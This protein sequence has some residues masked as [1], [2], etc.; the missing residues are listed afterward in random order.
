MRFLVFKRILLR[1]KTS[2]KARG[3]R[4]SHHYDVRTHG[5]FTTGRIEWDDLDDLDDL[6]DNDNDSAFLRDW[7]EGG[8]E[9]GD[10]AEE[11]LE[12]GG[13][14]W[15]THIQKSRVRRRVVGI[16]P[17]H[18]DIILGKIQTRYGNLPR[19]LD[20]GSA[21]NFSQASFNSA[22]I[23][24]RISDCRGNVGEDHHHRIGSRVP[25]TKDK[26]LAFFKETLLR[27]LGVLRFLLRFRIQQKL[28]DHLQVAET[29]KTATVID[30]VFDR[31]PRTH[32]RLDQ[33]LR[34]EVH[35]DGHLRGAC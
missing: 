2:A 18:A 34:V 1:A 35:H 17:F 24:S 29:I 25:T 13:L 14:S 4:L 30:V 31:L 22:F 15:V 21:F 16:E 6:H 27:D 23:L 5:R 7:R 10:R 11:F 26:R 12:D 8:R 28:E 32:L 33:P 3:C 20:V 9:R 19:S